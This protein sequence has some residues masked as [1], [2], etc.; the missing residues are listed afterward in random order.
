MYKGT[1][2]EESLIDERALNDFKVVKY[3]VT[4]EDD[5]SLRWHL[6]TVEANK[7]QIEKLANNL[8][9]EK[10]YAHFW[11]EDDIIAIYPNKIFT[12]KYSDKNTWKDAVEYGKSLD[13][14]VDQL[15]FEI[16]E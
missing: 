11:S 15:V 7:E 8:K 13:I 2:I 12:F 1:I 16:V 9:S 3:K 4:G 6:F 5:P 10:W 14:P